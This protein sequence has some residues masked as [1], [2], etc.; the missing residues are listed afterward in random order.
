MYGY[1][2]ISSLSRFSRDDV[3]IEIDRYR[4]I[5]VFWTLLAQVV[6]AAL[7]SDR[8][9]IAREVAPRGDRACRLTRHPKREETAG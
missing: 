8:G 2:H 7:W 6:T 4:T 3:R 1:S 9:S 5:V